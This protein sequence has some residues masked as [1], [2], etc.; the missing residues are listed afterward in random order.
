MFV[1]DQIRMNNKLIECAFSPIL[2]VTS[3]STDNSR[4][5]GLCLNI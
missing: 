5:G 2:S 1:Q 3:E 4:T